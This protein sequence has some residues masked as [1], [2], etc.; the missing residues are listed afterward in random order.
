MH[1]LLRTHGFIHVPKTGGTSIESLVN[2]SHAIIHR[3]YNNK[4]G[5]PGA[6]PWHLPPDVFEAHYR[7]A[8][9]RPTFCV[10][11][12]PRERLESCINWADSRAFRTPLEQLAAGFAHGRFRVQWTEERV[13]RMPQSWFVW[14]DE[15]RVLCDCVVAYEKFASAF[16]VHKN[17]RSAAR[18]LD[19]RLHNYTFPRHL[20]EMDALLHRTALS[21]PSLC[22]VPTALW[23]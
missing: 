19:P 17:K 3:R 13:H 18:A 8:Y 22:Y 2:A 1:A 14:S 6:S 21:A 11:R 10:V 4:R 9:K 12:E 5:M 23:P 7:D 20:Y 15:G 16:S